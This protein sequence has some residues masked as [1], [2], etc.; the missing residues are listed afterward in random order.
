MKPHRK[1]K[2]NR[3]CK[4]IGCR[5]RAMEDDSMCLPHV[6]AWYEAVWSHSTGLPNMVPKHLPLEY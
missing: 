6:R 4:I 3:Y 5:S 1:S 2:R